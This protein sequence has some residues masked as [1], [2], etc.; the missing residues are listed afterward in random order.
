MRDVKSS[1]KRKHSVTN[2]A[3]GYTQ[4]PTA[5]ATPETTVGR[6]ALTNAGPHRPFSIIY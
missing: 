5:D 1:P 3:P 6:W 4:K 2:A